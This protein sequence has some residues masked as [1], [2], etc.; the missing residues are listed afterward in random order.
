ML[1]SVDCRPAPA[2][3]IATANSRLARTNETDGMAALL[4][5]VLSVVDLWQNARCAASSCSDAVS[6]RAIGPYSGALQ[7]GAAMSCPTPDRQPPCWHRPALLLSDSSPAPRSP[8]TDRQ[9]VV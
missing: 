4:S 6:S 7:P 1:N 2:S 5:S 3:S 9:S 8:G